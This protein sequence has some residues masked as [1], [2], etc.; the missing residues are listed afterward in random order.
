[1]CNGLG[2]MKAALTLSFVAIVIVLATA[3]PR[4]HGGTVR[5]AGERGFVDG[6]HPLH[7]DH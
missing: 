7:Q 3:L 1:M 4:V 2:E 6:G 5:L